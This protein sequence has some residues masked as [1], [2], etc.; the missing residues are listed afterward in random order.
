MPGVISLFQIKMS[1]QIAEKTWNTISPYP[2]AVVQK[3]LLRKKS[4]S[5]GAQWIAIR[6]WQWP[7][8]SKNGCQ[9]SNVTSLSMAMQY[10]IPTGE[11]AQHGSPESLLRRK[12][13]SSA[14]VLSYDFHEFA[15]LLFLFYRNTKAY[16][17]L[18]KMCQ[19]LIMI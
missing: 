11:E 7:S 16:F 1:C 6:S 10:V 8:E 3:V 14:A 17:P 5:Q 18:A 19:S 2:A 4:W 15:E 13:T 9:Y 12:L